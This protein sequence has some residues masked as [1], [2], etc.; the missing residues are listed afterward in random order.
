MKTSHISILRFLVTFATY[1]ASSLIAENLFPF[2]IHVYEGLNNI[3]VYFTY[4]SITLLKTFILVWLIKSI[5]QN[6]LKLICT[7]V[8]V[9]YGLQTFM[10]FTE[11]WYFR[12]V[13]SF[14]G[15][16]I[17]A[18]VIQ[19]LI[20]L[21]ITVPVAVWVYGL[22]NQDILPGKRITFSLKWIWLALLYVVIYF[23]FRYTTI[24]LSDVLRAYYWDDLAMLSFFEF[25]KINWE[26]YRG[27]FFF[28]ATRGFLWIVFSAPVIFWLKIKGKNKLILLI[29]LMAFLPALQLF[30]PNPLL[31]YMVKLAHFLG[32]AFSNIIYAGL[33]YFSFSKHIN[34]GNS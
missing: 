28:Q 23:V 19:N 33:I 14:T 9:M 15:P 24:R 29:L 16:N 30:N 31:N 21:L 11:I 6:K 8:F 20:T 22:Y 26:T 27:I 17:K 32:I 13:Y 10:I 18:F 5:N 2:N 7:V 3:C 4:I 12:D 34:P 25:I 1:F